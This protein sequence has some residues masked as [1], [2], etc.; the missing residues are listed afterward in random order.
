MQVVI[1][2]KSSLAE[3]VRVNEQC[4]AHG[5]SF[6]RADIKGVFGSVFCDFGKAFEVLDVDGMLHK[7]S[8]DTNLYTS[9][10]EKLPIGAGSFKLHR[11]ASR[12]L[13]V[14]AHL[15]LFALLQEP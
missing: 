3:A 8:C 2:T 7:A 6:I 5:I 4:H 15:L 13:T 14:S 11:L 12:K 1:L 10:L 9:L